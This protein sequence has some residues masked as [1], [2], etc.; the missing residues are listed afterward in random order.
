MSAQ[1]D[2]ATI[3]VAAH[4]GETIV[5]TNTRLEYDNNDLS[6]IARSFVAA[7]NLVS[8][9]TAFSSLD[10]LVTALGDIAEMM[11]LRSS[12]VM[13]E[14]IDVTPNNS[15]AAL[16]DLVPETANEWVHAIVSKLASYLLTVEYKVILMRMTIN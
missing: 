6:S 12:G 9:H 8:Q 14:V 15:K 16:A 7:V 4:D 5:T 13:Y 1:Y 10:D 11:R 2:G 3:I